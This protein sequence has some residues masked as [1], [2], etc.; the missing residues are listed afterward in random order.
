[1]GQQLRDAPVIPLEGF[2]ASLELRIARSTEKTRQKSPGLHTGSVGRSWFLMLCRTRPVLGAS[3]ILAGCL[4]VLALTGCGNSTNVSVAGPSI[5]RCGV[6]IPAVVRLAPA[7][8]GSR[9]AH[10]NHRARMRVV[11]TIRIF[12]DCPKHHPRTRTSQPW[13]LNPAEP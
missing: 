5:T 8:G 13:V 3:P 12:L 11:R 9:D 4:A 10:R 2:S 1:M 6:S 7:A